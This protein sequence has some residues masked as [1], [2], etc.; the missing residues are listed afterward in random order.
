ML[1]VT[2]PHR[3][4]ADYPGEIEVSLGCGSSDSW[5]TSDPYTFGIIV[6]HYDPDKGMP[7]PAETG[8]SSWKLLMKYDEPVLLHLAVPGGAVMT[9]AYLSAQFPDLAQLTGAALAGELHDHLQG[10]LERFRSSDQY[11]R[12][13]LRFADPAQYGDLIVALTA[14]IPGPLAATREA[15]LEDLLR[16][17]GS[18]YEAQAAWYAAHGPSDGETW[19]DYNAEVAAFESLAADSRAALEDQLAQAQ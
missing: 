6:Q 8:S 16:A 12:L 1:I 13:P 19:E 17:W 3:H 15:V 7:V 2:P 4:R 9:P 14:Q 11:L 5:A 18:D 10:L